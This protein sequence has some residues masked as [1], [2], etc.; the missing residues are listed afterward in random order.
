MNII[1]RIHEFHE[2]GRFVYYRRYAYILYAHSLFYALFRLMQLSKSHNHFEQIMIEFQFFIIATA[3]ICI[4]LENC[5]SIYRN[6]KIVTCHCLLFFRSSQFLRKMITMWWWAA[7]LTYVSLLPVFALFPFFRCFFLA[8]FAYDRLFTC[9]RLTF[10]P[11]RMPMK[12][13]KMKRN[14]MVHALW[15][16]VF[17]VTWCFFLSLFSASINFSHVRQTGFCISFLFDRML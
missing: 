5:W 11:N 6:N 7:T 17:D 14:E 10:S 16:K 4:L 3:F 12:W 1:V 8:S 9:S 13:N 2:I 15:K